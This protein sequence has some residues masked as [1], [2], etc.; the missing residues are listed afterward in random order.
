MN[1]KP[2]QSTKK[3]Y[4]KIKDSS[5]LDRDGDEGVIEGQKKKLTDIVNDNGFREIPVSKSHSTVAIKGD[6]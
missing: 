5:Q 4:I 6:N 2:R 1:D 3:K